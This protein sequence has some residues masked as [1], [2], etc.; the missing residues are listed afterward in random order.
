MSRLVSGN[1][2][3]LR[4]KLL[5]ETK[6]P[7][8]SLNHNKLT[9][10]NTICCRGS[11][12]PRQ[13]DLPPWLASQDPLGPR[14]SVS[15][16]PNQTWSSLESNF[17]TCLTVRLLLCSSVLNDTFDST[18]NLTAVLVTYYNSYVL[19]YYFGLSVA[20]SLSF[21]LFFSPVLSCVLTKIL[22][23]YINCGLVSPLVMEMFLYITGITRK[24]RIS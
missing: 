13:K 10:L 14:Q 23:S 12:E 19:L 7:G 9:T 24:I 2:L 1:R 6:N 8:F 11:R 17:T 15:K 20:G 5:S 22:L 21:V 18:D 3:G 4:L 16:P